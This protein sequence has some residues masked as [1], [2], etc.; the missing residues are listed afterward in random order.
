MLKQPNP[1]HDFEVIQEPQNTPDPLSH[2]LSYVRFHFTKHFN[3]LN[4]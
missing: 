2:L 1:D 3:N 4:E